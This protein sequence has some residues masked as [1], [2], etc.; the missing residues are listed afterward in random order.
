[1]KKVIAYGFILIA[2]LILLSHSVLPHHHH[3]KQVCIERTFC[4]TNS[5]A[6][7]H[8]V[9]WQNHKC[10]QDQDRNSG[11]SCILKQAIVLPVHQ[12]RH[13]N[14]CS[15]HKNNHSYDFQFILF[16]VSPETIITTSETV[17]SDS[18]VTSFYSALLQS[19]LSLR[20]PPTV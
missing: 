14:E 10:N 3:D 2:N 8:Q 9:N 15:D 6:H 11:S 17:K 12:S 20:G 16:N 4:E 13:L 5:K 19:S 1:M 7:Q 18:E